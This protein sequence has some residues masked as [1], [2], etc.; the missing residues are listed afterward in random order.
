VI[1]EAD[2]D[3]LLNQYRVSRGQ[4]YASQYQ[5]II[6]AGYRLRGRYRWSVDFIKNLKTTLDRRRKKR[7]PGSQ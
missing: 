6:R 7:K 1:T 3:T 5:A 4:E 2:F